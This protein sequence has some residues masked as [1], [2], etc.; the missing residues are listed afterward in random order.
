MG[1][2]LN[3]LE[4]IQKCFKKLPNPINILINIFLIYT[5]LSKKYEN[6]NLTFDVFNTCLF[7]ID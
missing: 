3:A 1:S 6:D 2:G 4:A 5:Q 7:K